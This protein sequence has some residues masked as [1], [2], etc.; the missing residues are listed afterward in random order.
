M[1]ERERALERVA[2]VLKATPDSVVKRAHAIVEERR[3]LERRLEEAMKGGGDQVRQLLAQAREVDGLRI[4]G[5]LV[6]VADAKELQA[7]GDAVREQFGVAALGATFEDGRSTL[8]VVASDRARDRG[9]RADAVVRELAT[10]AGGRGGGKPHMAQAGVPDAARL[11]EALGQLER[12]VR[13][14][15]GEKA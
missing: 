1:R 15:V 4:V 6:T 13:S 10:V 3:A 8:L 12:V 5:S 2:E 14:L 7:L 11:P 9:A